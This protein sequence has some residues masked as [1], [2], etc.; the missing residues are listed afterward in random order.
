MA[1]PFSELEKKNK[2]TLWILVEGKNQEARKKENK[3]PI[4]TDGVVLDK[5]FF[6]FFQLNIFF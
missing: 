1:K 2:L 6:V 5:C 4:R 3:L